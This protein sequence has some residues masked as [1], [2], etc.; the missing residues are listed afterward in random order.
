MLIGPV[1]VPETDNDVPVHSSANSATLMLISLQKL[2]LRL[3]EAVLQ[4]AC[5]E[6]V[7]L[8]FFGLLIL[9]FSVSVSQ[10]VT[11]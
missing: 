11:L 7:F 3:Q 10:L 6:S 4:F 9:H 1:G 2:C 5:V 8:F